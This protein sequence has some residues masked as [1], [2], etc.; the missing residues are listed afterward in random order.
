MTRTVLAY[1]ISLGAGI[2][3][4]LLYWLMGVATPAPPW[5][6][7]CGLLGILFGEACVRRLRERLQRRRGRGAPAPSDRTTGKD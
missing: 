1:V 2:L 5:Q 7:L 4:G 3:T 6:A